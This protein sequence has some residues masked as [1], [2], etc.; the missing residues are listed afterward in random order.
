MMLLATIALALV[1]PGAPVKK[2]LVIGV[3][4]CRPDALS[5][6][7][8]PY[9]DSLVRNGCLA[10]GKADPLTMSGP[11]WSTV[12]CG[13]WAGKHGVTDNSFVGSNYR[14]YPD[15]LTLV[16]RYKP[17]LR[18]VAVSEWKPVLEKIVLKADFMGRSSGEGD[19]AAALE[20]A[21]QI[22]DTDPDVVFVHFGAVDTAGH[23]FGYGPTVPQYLRAIEGTDKNVGLL[24]AAVQSRKK[25]LDEDWLVILTSDHGGSGT[26]H[27]QA[28]P[29]HINVPFIVSGPSSA[30]G[31]D[32]IP[33][34]VD[35]APTVFAHLGLTRAYEVDWDGVPVG[36][37][38]IDSAALAKQR[39]GSIVGFSPADRF[40]IDRQE[41]G[42]RVG[43][44]ALIVR[45]TVDGS[46]PTGSSL[47]ATSFVLENSA[48]VRARAF[49][50][51]E[52]V[53]PSSF[54]LFTVQNDY[55]H[56]VTPRDV[57]PGLHYR[58]VQRLFSS[59]VKVDFSKPDT[60]GIA[61]APSSRVGTGEN[62]AVSFIGL[63]KITEQGVYQFGLYC[64]DGGVLRIG[65][66]TVVDHD[67]SHSASM[68]S[69]YV[70]LRAGW[71][72]FRLDYFQAGGD[73]ALSLVMG[74]RGQ[75][76]EEVKP[77][78]FGH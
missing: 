47:P 65:D 10:V 52:P 78:M 23:A 37:K 41:V 22:T 27:G 16:E 69:G 36:L 64:D 4:G 44:P 63:I 70:A 12:L 74:L 29:E 77:S 18:T 17:S 19:E 35:V 59:V 54:A 5:R 8:T 25:I 66:R 68:K 30:D 67:G 20:A 9:I 73:S 21:T 48:L 32:V 55:L 26:S 31:F 62:F 57:A 6:A 11:C 56:A 28:I 15:F 14:E 13:V 50:D 33:T 61:G 38:G 3:D 49:K 1:M 34:L 75:K 51:R 24:L 7:S 46:M 43:D 45:F 60:S 58:V 76:M 39:D 40:L 42:L 72:F 2:V 53:G 71:H